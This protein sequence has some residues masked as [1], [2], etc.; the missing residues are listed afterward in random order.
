MPG[1]D[2]AVSG[3]LTGLPEKLNLWN[4]A[5]VLLVIIAAVVVSRVIM[6]LV[7]RALKKSKLD[8][9]LVKLIRTAVKLL[10]GVVCVLIIC[11]TLGVEVT[12]LLA[13]FSVVGLALSLAM[14]GLL[15]NLAGGMVLL[16]A[17]PFRVGDFVEVD[18]VTGTVKETS[19]MYTKLDTT[20]NRLVVIPN[21]II[22]E[23]KVQNF[24]AEETRRVEVTF[25]ASYDSPIDQVKEAVLEAL[26]DNQLTLDQPAPVVGVAEFGASA[27]R[28]N[29]WVWCKGSDY[30]PALY[31]VNESIKAGLD[32]RGLNMT[33]DHINVH[34]IE[35]D[36]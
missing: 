30:W 36:K 18:G 16:W 10:V 7:G 21:K 23:A 29:V 31:S 27:I 11:E 9:V 15:A 28:Y 13:L 22:S 34:M 6:S 12:S 20:D 35:Q 24:A 8:P 25:S 5:F 26:A 4:I 33:Y 17:K 32:R 1:V 3:V 14:Q 19:L 2:E